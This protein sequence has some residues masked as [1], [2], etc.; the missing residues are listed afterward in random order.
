MCGIAGLIMDELDP[1]GGEWIT[2]MTQVQHHRGP[3]DGG[4]VVFGLNGAP[5]QQRQLGR[6]QEPVTWGYLPCHV[7]LGAR[8]LAIQDLSSA[9][10]Q[11]MSSTD[12][13]VWIVFNGEIY[14]HGAL[15]GELRSRGATFVGHSD[16]EVLLAAYR[17]WGMDCFSRLEG[18]WG[19]AVVDW[20]ARRVVLSRDRLGIKP[21]YLSR[22]DGGL[23]FASEITPLL[24]LSGAMRGV[25]ESALRDFLIAGSV[26]HA[27]STFFDGIYAAPPGCA[28]EWPLRR[29]TSAEFAARAT[30]YWQP[31]PAWTRAPA[32]M[33]DEHENDAALPIRDMLA[34]SVRAHLTGDVDVG[35]CLSGGI[36]SSSV[37]MLAAR[38]ATGQSH[39]SQHTFTA[40]LPGSPLDESRYA[41]AVLAAAPMLRGHTVSPTGEGLLTNID[42]LIRHQE[43]PFGS[44][45]IYMQWEVMRLARETGVKVLLDGQGGDELFCGYEGYWPPM[46]AHFLTHG[47]WIGLVSQFR[48]VPPA[49]FSHGS[50]VARTLA[51]ALP[52]AVRQ[53]MSTRRQF[54]RQIWLDRDLMDA[55]PAA[56]MW[57]AL[58][59]SPPAPMVAL[60]EGPALSRHLWGI[61]LSES[62]PG[63]LRFED[64]NSMAFGIE[65]RVPMLDRTFVEAAMQ[66]PPELKLRDG[67]TKRILRAAMR[68]IVPDEILARRDKIGFTAPTYEW[69][70]GSLRTWWGDLIGSTSFRDRGCF[71]SKGVA[72]LTRQFDSGTT[73]P[74]H[75]AGLALALWRAALTDAWARQ[76]LDRRRAD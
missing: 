73:N 22:F 20:I 50:L 8:R 71:D 17:A 58:G 45:S 38:E 34:A 4:A 49:A 15:R 57:T 41:Q 33:T 25:N 51:H 59:I 36:D 18:M 37:V 19:L 3:D 66:A 56:D 72:E 67:T 2:R 26:D 13:H 35:S 27:N 61:L 69:M 1:R 64:R 5:I 7:A 40:T 28:I 11:P 68:G 29:S 24:T 23:A 63:L 30:R 52:A 74:E 16:T 21:L 12:G 47:R 9:G 62:L 32:R 10:H 55:D 65:A 42:A 43:Q 14:N 39:W 76:F 44:P 60:E 75:Q 70:S 53:G 54:R 48:R 46:L 31:A 6:P